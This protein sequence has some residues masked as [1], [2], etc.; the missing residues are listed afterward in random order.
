MQT[1]QHWKLWLPAAVALTLLLHSRA[2]ADEPRTLAECADEYDQCFAS[3]G[4]FGYFFCPQAY[5][6]CVAQARSQLP[7][8]ITQV[9]DQVDACSRAAGVCRT[10]AEGA[11]DKL[12]ACDERHN[13]CIINAFGLSIEPP[14]DG[15]K[16]ML[17]VSLATRCLS[18]AETLSNLQA[19]QQSLGRCLATPTPPLRAARA[20]NVVLFA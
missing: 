16:D 6:Q 11:Q 13:A 4:F 1:T 17:C 8:E 19:C 20:S 14:P 10:A 3:A 7:P 15:K 5:A 2:A 18:S 9:L 12:A